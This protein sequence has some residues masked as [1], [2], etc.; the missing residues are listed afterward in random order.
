MDLDIYFE[1]EEKDSYQ[2]NLLGLTFTQ[3]LKKNLR[4]KWMVSR[5]DDNENESYD[6]IGNYLFGER[7]FD[8]SSSTFG[9]ITNPLGAGIYQNY[10]RNKLNIAVWNATHKGYLDLEKILCSGE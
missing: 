2:T 9:L 7:D 4:L 1:G 3:Q 10:A 8:K 6:I 5:F